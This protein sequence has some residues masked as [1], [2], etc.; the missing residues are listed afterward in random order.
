MGVNAAAEVVAAPAPDAV[1]AAAALAVLAVAWAAGVELPLADPA[2]PPQPARAPIAA[3]PIAVPA[4]LA[5]R[6]ATP[7]AATPIAV[8]ASL[9]RRAAVLPPVTGVPPRCWPIGPPPRPRPRFP[10]FLG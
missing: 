9:A 3:T 10:D 4:S 6:V 8:P 7:I 2:E 5:P 1:A